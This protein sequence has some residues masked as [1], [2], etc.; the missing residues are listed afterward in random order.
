MCKEEGTQSWKRE[1]LLSAIKLH[2]KCGLY[3][4]H[5]IQKR[6]VRSKI[7]LVYKVLQF[8]T[9]GLQSTD[10]FLNVEDHCLNPKHTT[11]TWKRKKQ[12][13]TRKKQR[14]VMYAAISAPNPPVTGAS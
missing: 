1:S 11:H 6:E 9:M 4:L 3:E 12:N 13:L 8:L 14:S 2:A 7:K 5:S 10:H